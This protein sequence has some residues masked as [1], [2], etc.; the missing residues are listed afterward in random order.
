MRL[1]LCYYQYTKDKVETSRGSEL[2]LV[3]D[4]MVQ[5]TL[6]QA[7]LDGSKSKHSGSN[8]TE[9][10]CVMVFRQSS[11]NGSVGG[12][13][14]QP[15]PRVSG[16]GINHRQPPRASFESEGIAFCG[17]QLD[18]RERLVR[19]QQCIVSNNRKNKSYLEFN[20]A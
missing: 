18:R 12:R 5:T 14:V 2:K 16:C 11:S 10:P 13:T 20:E 4:L 17:H 9:S 1:L 19:C 6:V 3:V 7:G 15:D 8:W